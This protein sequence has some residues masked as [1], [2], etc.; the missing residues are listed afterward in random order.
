[1]TIVRVGT[2]T[3]HVPSVS[4]TMTIIIAVMSATVLGLRRSTHTTMVPIA[5]SVIISHGAS[6]VVMTVSASVTVV[7]EARLIIVTIRIA[8]AVVVLSIATIN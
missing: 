5:P 3:V 4:S 2:L 8:S 1:M 6:V 7:S